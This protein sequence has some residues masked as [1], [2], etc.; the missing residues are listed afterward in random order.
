MDTDFRDSLLLTA[1]KTS[2]D[3]GKA[4]IDIYNS[5]Y[6]VDFKSDRSPLTSADT[7]SN[8]IIN[9]R[10]D[11]THIPLISEE[12]A[13]I[14]Y[15]I[16]KYWKVYWL[17]DPLDGTKEFINRNGEFT[18]NIAL[19]AENLP[20]I[21]VIYAPTLDILYFASLIRGAFRME[22]AILQIN[23]SNS[24]SKIIELS[25]SIPV[26]KQHRTLIVVASRSHM[27]E[28]TQKYIDILKTRHGEISTV[29]RGSSL[30]FCALAEG[31]ADIYPRFGPTMEWDNAAGNAILNI[32]GGKVVKADGSGQLQYNKPDLLNPEF[33]AFGGIDYF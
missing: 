3:A 22:N 19:I 32:A 27:N 33:I 7:A 15:E 5:G 2:L 21:G 31:S 1:I 17:I 4:I 10:L 23:A 26:I 30:K 24:I 8:Q 14:P 28:R 20:V 29:S 13:A 6:S 12:N 25:Q 16:R 11:E 18:V 9:S